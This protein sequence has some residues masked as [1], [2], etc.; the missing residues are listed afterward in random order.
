MSEYGL[1][2]RIMKQDP[3]AIDEIKTLEEAKDIIKMMAGNVYLNGEIYQTIKESSEISKRE[4]H[5]S[6][7]RIK[8]ILHAGID[9]ERYAP[10]TDDRYPSRINRI[11]EFDEKDIVV[12][13]RFRLDYVTDENGNDYRGFY[14]WTSYVVD[15]DYVFGNKIRI[16]TYRTIYEFEKVE[17]V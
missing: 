12:G 6:C 3:G 5:M 2:K 7:Y 4:K 13:E 8:S 1:Y 15:W 17:E 9:G 16:E 14:K 11:V 10:R